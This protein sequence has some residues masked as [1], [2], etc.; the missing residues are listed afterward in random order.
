MCIVNM[1]ITELFYWQL[2]GR[3]FYEF[4]KTFQ[5]RKVIDKL[6]GVNKEV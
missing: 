2:S 4:K 1:E 5:E 3:A 6:L